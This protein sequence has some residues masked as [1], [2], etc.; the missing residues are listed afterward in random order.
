MGV[1][2]TLQ[3]ARTTI[4]NEIVDELLFAYGRRLPAAADISALRALAS[5]GVPDRSIRHVTST[6]YAW[7]WDVRSLATDDGQNV[8]QPT[9]VVGNKPGRW[10]RRT[11]TGAT[12]T[13]PTGYLVKSELFNEDGND[14]E[15]FMERLFG[16]VPAMLLSFDDIERQPKSTE[17]GA[18]D[19][20]TATF[21]LFVISFD[22]RGAQTARQ[23]SPVA[24]EDAVDPGTAAMLGDAKA[25]LKGATL[26]IDD[27]AYVRIGREYPV[28]RDIARSRFVEALEV[29]VYYT[30]T[31]PDTTTVPLSSPYAF[32]IHY[33][34]ADFDQSGRLDTSNDV[35]STGLQI[36][37]GDGLTKSFSGGT[38]NFNGSPVTVAGASNTFP[39]NSIT[40]RDIDAQG[41]LY[42]TATAVGDQ[43]PVVAAGRIRLGAT[44]TDSTGVRLDRLLAASLLS[45]GPVDKV[46]PPISSI[47]ISPT[48]ITVPAGV[49]L[50][51]TA[52]ATYADGSQADITTQVTW[53]SDNTQT[54]VTAG[55]AHTT[56]PGTAHITASLNG[57]TSNTATL[58][59]T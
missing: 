31:L 53:S 18:L 33:Q 44:V 59:A 50:M 9:D 45:F 39:A 8:V 27:V 15:I 57:V 16:G 58:T 23:G 48:S 51:F 29:F 52:V 12:S 19:W 38:L 20:C 25:L 54:T 17:P 34:L 47:A 35:T 21:T 2:I 10:L 36:A 43:P 26:G 32:D 42:Y 22:A 6:G 7:K 55:L 49:D 28:V 40:Y 56:A 14:L 30:E 24:A 41:V 3:N 13:A 4:E 37:L 11:T 5:A 46:T 1:S